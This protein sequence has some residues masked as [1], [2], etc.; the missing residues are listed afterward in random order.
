[1]KLATLLGLLLVFTHPAQAQTREITLRNQWNETHGVLNGKEF[2][3]FQVLPFAA[4]A[5]CHGCPT[6]TDFSAN[7][8]G[9]S[10]TEGVAGLDDFV[11][12]AIDR[13]DAEDYDVFTAKIEGYDA[14][15]VNALKFG[16]YT[17]TAYIQ[18]NNKIIWVSVSTADDLETTI[19]FLDSALTEFALPIARNSQ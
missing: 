16:R 4:T 15:I 1:M 2:V 3:Q 13:I 14:S 5:D 12:Q 9:L 11:A 8:V 10:E 7:L 6:Y 17:S 19:T 18:A